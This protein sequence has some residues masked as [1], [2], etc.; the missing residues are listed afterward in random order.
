MHILSPYARGLGL[1]DCTIENLQKNPKN[2]FAFKKKTGSAT[3]LSAPTALTCR[4][5]YFAVTAASLAVESDTA[6]LQR[7]HTAWRTKTKEL[8]NNLTSSVDGGVSP[9]GRKFFSLLPR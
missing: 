1:H 2:I 4:M 9:C 6:D 8:V 5:Y 7:I 3:P